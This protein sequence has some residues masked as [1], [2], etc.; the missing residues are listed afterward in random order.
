MREVFKNSKLVNKTWIQLWVLGKHD[1][2]LFFSHFGEG[3]QF[4]YKVRRT[5]GCRGLQLESYL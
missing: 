2:R 1:Y 4:D 3:R 5:L